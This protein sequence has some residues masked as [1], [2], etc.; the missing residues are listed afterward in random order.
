MEQLPLERPAVDAR[1]TTV[2]ILEDERTAMSGIRSELD[3]DPRIVVTAC[4]R[5]PAAMAAR[6]LQ[7]APEIVI[8][9]L[10]LN[11]DDNA[12]YEFLKSI[13]AQAPSVRFVVYSGYLSLP[14]FIRLFDQGV[15]VVVKKARYPRPTLPELVHT[16]AEGGR[17]YD[18]DLVSDMRR[19]LD[20]E[21]L[22]R[23]DH[24]GELARGPLSAREL[25]V[26]TLLARRRSNAEIAEI[27]V[28]TPN[29]VRAHVRSILQK[30]KGRDRY[31]VVLIAISH[32]WIPGVTSESP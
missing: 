28:I 25:E 4:D 24:P 5:D 3:G 13:R 22:G 10:R 32:G 31:E 6:I 21:R 15:H 26:L 20:E 14:V 12:G 8:L 23:T 16:V 11:D 2:A 18:P 29:T 27:L 1:K 9:D 30:L 17:Y 7:L 19:Y